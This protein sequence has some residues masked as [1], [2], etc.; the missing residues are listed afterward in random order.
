MWRKSHS[1]DENIYKIFAGESE[2]PR[3]LGEN[4]SVRRLE[5]NIKIVWFEDTN[6]VHTTQDMDQ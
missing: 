3:P 6:C 1:T 2:G 4:T 5:D